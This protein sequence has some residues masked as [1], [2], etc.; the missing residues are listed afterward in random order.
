MADL[1]AQRRRHLGEAR[2]E[3]HQLHLGADLLLLVG[4]GLPHT[5]G[6]G[7]GGIGKADLVVSII[8]GASPEADG[9]DRGGIGP[10]LA[11]DVDLGLV[12]VDPGVVVGAVDAGDMVE[13]V[14]LRDRRAD[15]AALEEVGAADR[16]AV[17]ARRRIGLAPVCDGPGLVG[18]IGVARDAVIRRVAAVDVGMEREIAGAGVEQHAALDTAIDRAE[19]GT[20]L[21]RD[22]GRCPSGC[23]W[24]LHRH[25]ITLE[26]LG[27]AGWQRV[28]NPVV[29]RADDAADRG[30]SIAQGGRPAHHF[31]LIGRE[32][33]DRD[34]VILAE[35]GC[36]VRIGAVLDDADA[37]DVEAPDDR[38]A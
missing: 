8:R 28:R 1:K 20:R 14:V 12:R 26:R 35:I 36:A 2:V 33:I 18:Q 24:R 4:E 21:G 22:A 17:R 25:A 30:R 32:R 16:G 15:I 38:P 3:R 6:V 10:V 34:E 29:G 23:E 5:V 13:R 37:V 31:D 9:V 19:R 27:T 7:I 11:L